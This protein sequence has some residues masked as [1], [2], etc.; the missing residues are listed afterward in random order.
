MR[1]GT[2]AVAVGLLLGLV[3]AAPAQAGTVSLSDYEL[4]FRAAPGETNRLALEREPTGGGIRVVDDGAPLVPGENCAPA[5]DGRGVVCA[6]PGREFVASI[7]AALGDGDDE[8]TARGL[9]GRGDVGLHGEEGHDRLEAAAGGRLTNHDPQLGTFPNLAGGPGDDVLLGGPGPDQ[10]DGGPGADVLRGGPG[11]DLVTYGGSPGAVTVALDDRPGDGPPAENDDVGS[12]V[13]EV[14]GTRG[15]DVIVGSDGPNALDGLG[16]SD[17]LD[18]RGGADVLST[19]RGAD[20]L[21]GGAGPDTFRVE[22]FDAE[23]VATRVEARDGERDRVGCDARVAM[24]SFDPFDSLS[25]CAPAAARPRYD[26][27]RVRRSG[28]AGL[29]LG[30]HGHS[31]IPCAGK[32]LVRRQVNFAPAGPVIGRGRFRV[33]SG[34]TAT[35]ATIRFTRSWTRL[36]ERRGRL[37]AEAELITLRELPRSSRSVPMALELLA[38]R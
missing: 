32:I 9:A 20:R 28:T 31:D 17:L 24:L 1:G 36:L 4:R 29:L 38:P 12:D 37:E 27:L 21:V 7:G 35:R 26:R 34:G 15:D 33:P 18:G 23:L 19:S 3:A 10:L 6:P 2:T 14:D 16:G 25:E 5:G 8:A 11:S 22:K 13:E 30:C